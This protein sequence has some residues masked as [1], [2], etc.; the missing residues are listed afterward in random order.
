MARARDHGQVKEVKSWAPAGFFA[1]V[2]V[3]LDHIKTGD[4]FCYAR[5]LLLFSWY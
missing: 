4:L 3:G 5:H 2:S 1:G